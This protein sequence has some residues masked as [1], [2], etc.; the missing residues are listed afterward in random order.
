MLDQSPEII[1][2]EKTQYMP[3]IFDGGNHI[4]GEGSGV[5]VKSNGNILFVH[6]SKY[7]F[8]NEEIIDQPVIFEYDGKSRKLISAWGENYFKSPHGLAVDKYDNVWI[9]DTQTNKVYKFD[10]NRNLVMTIGED[11]RVGLEL[12]LRIRNKIRSFPVT[13]NKY[14]LAK[15]TDVVI[16]ENGDVIISDGYRN[17]RVVRFNS[18]G[19]FIWE[20]N[21]YGG[22]DY[23]FNLPHGIAVDDGGRI[24]V[25]DRSNA[26]IQV[27]DGDG[28]YLKTWKGINIGRPFG[29][30]VR[31]SRAYIADGG[32]FLYGK[33]DN[34]QSRIV[35]CDL[36]GQVL[37]HFGVFGNA[38]GEMIVPH[39]IAVDSQGNIFVAEIGN[40]RLQGFYRK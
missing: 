30:E 23:E 29:N 27:F 32:D 10:G 16:A 20:I 17:S 31:G 34:N 36:E 40:K 18:S 39:D 37:E 1:P 28:K 12:Q 5:A 11:Y 14:I 35:V 19:K 9:T 3:E 38:K 13:S 4:I 33:K 7:N 2:V 8:N 21:H 24:Y 25:A 22:G 6:R 26:R 15:P